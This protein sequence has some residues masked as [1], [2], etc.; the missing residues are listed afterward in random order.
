ME[1]RPELR[2]KPPQYIRSPDC[3]LQT[4]F[5]HPILRTNPTYRER[6]LSLGGHVGGHPQEEFPPWKTLVPPRASP[7]SEASEPPP[8]PPEKA[9]WAPCA[10]RG[11]VGAAR[12]SQRVSLSRHSPWVLPGRSLGFLQ[13]RY[14]D[15]T[16]LQNPRFGLLD[17]ARGVLGGC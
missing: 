4:A 16:L 5:S 9:W 3:K 13:S 7:A 14:R 11:S 15:A 1:G 2:R 10:R 12:E 6:T 8:A 17:W